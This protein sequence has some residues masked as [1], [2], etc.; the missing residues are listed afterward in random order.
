[1]KS[2]EQNSTAQMSIQALRNEVH[3]TLTDLLRGYFDISYVA[4]QAD[5]SIVLNG[6]FKRTTGIKSKEEYNKRFEADTEFTRKH[7]DKVAKRLIDLRAYHE[8]QVS[9]FKDVRAIFPSFC[10][11]PE[12]KMGAENYSFYKHEASALRNVVTLPIS[13][14]TEQPQEETLL[15]VQDKISDVTDNQGFTTACR[16]ADSFLASE[17][18]AFL[19]F[20]ET[21]SPEEINKLKHQ[22]YR[23]FSVVDGKRVEGRYNTVS[24]AQRMLHEKQEKLKKYEEIDALFEKAK[25]IDH[26]K[27]RSSDSEERFYEK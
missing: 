4:S 21:L 20:V 24:Y 18:E 2:I 3:M 25:K 14:E 27:F 13:K 22:K 10:V 12:K 1:M 9:F 17:L 16:I 11:D 23:V 6:I 19:S 8:V 5:K 7:N 15:E 26:F